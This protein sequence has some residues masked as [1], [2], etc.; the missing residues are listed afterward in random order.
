MAFV[1]QAERNLEHKRNDM[2]VTVGP[3]TYV[4]HS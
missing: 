1:Y 3:G 2:P 4:G